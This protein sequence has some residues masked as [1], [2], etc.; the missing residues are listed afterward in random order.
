M[1]TACA[2]RARSAAA[3]QPTRTART[4]AR[5]AVPVVLQRQ[6][7]TVAD[8][9]SPLEREADRVADRVM[10]MPTPGGGGIGVS[11][12]SKASVQ[13][14]CPECEEGLQR[15]PIEDEEE[16][17]MA[18]ERPHAAPKTALLRQVE[19]QP[20]EDQVAPA[21]PIATDEDLLLVAKAEGPTGAAAPAGTAERIAALRGGGRPL[22]ADVRGF[23]E[24]RFGA[25][26]GQ[27]RIHAGGRASALAHSVRAQAFT[28]GGDI[29]FGDGRFRPDTQAGRWLLAHE[30]THTL[31]QSDAA[32]EPQARRMIQRAT[33]ESVPPPSAMTA[34]TPATTTP[35]EPIVETISFSVGASG[36]SG[37]QEA[38][39][40]SFLQRWHDAGATHPVRVDGFASCDGGPN[41]NWT[42]SCSRADVVAAVLRAPPSGG[43]R[44]PPAMLE[45]FANGETDQFSASDLAANRVVTIRTATALG[46]AVSGEPWIASWATRTSG[47][48]AADNCMILGRQNL[49][50]GAVVGW[51]GNGIEHQALI[52]NHDP[53][54]SYDVKRT[55]AHQAWRRW[56]VLWLGVW[57][58]I[59][60]RPAGTPDDTHDQDE[61]LT[62]VV[63]PAGNPYVYV[64]DG[65]GF[66]PPAAADRSTDYVNITNF[67]EFVR[68]TRPDGTTYD[69]PLTLNWHTKTWLSRTGAVWAVDAARSRIGLGHQASLSP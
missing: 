29:V 50:V 47:T 53:A 52:A 58:N 68:I 43:R 26:F 65:P 28:V 31:Q 22:G 56:P 17:A 67:I 14:L 60:S 21:R 55:M 57:S 63:P 48:T 69:D 9:D 11:R 27:V 2:A 4:Q 20:E 66:M 16:E 38:M 44:V 46:P 15:Q 54:Y 33:C 7:L 25:D 24:P 36:L 10:R 5:T 62:P 49:G 12:G 30:L 32:G 40:E 45:V 6:P 37:A 59:G 61:C 51:L 34:C 1:R 3:S 39:I 19:E 23:M 42:L 35:P 18:V 8:V 64:F 41:D 13:R